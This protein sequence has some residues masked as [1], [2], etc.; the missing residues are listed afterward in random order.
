M[1]TPYIGEIKLFA[2]NFEIR[3]WAFCNG[4]LLSIADYDALYALIGT[5]Y[6][7]DGVNTFGLPNLQSRIALHQG[8]G[9]GL[10]NRVIG[11]ASGAESVTLL[12]ANLPAHTHQAIATTVPGTASAPANALPATP[13]LASTEFLYLSGGA[14]GTTDAP[15]APASVSS[16]GGNQPHDNIMPILALNYLIALEGIFPSQN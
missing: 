13:A 1:A 5:T 6:G 12:P 16:A 11:E 3:G 8:Q 9:P 15:P 10:T 14:S 4:Q 2:G 7:G